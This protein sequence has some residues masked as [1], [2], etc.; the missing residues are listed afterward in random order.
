MTFILNNALI[1]PNIGLM[2]W[3]LLTFILLLV[4]L[5][6]FAWKPIMDGMKSREVSIQEALNEAKKAREDMKNLKSENEALLAEARGERDKI[7][8]EGR[9]IREK[10]ISDAKGLA[11]IE[12]R[13][14]IT[15]AKESIEKEKL[16]AMRELREQVVELSIDAA[17]K[18]LK[19]ELADKQVQA[20]LVETYL[21]DVNAG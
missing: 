14:I 13:N 1:T 5:S 7:L 4:V 3:T 20:Q 6:K 17:S 10:L 2:F 12:S 16:A 9:E 21:N 19:R 15:Q 18:I 11:Q 8:K